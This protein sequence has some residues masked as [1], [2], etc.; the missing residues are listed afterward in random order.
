MKCVATCWATNPTSLV[1]NLIG[2]LVLSAIAF[3]AMRGA[4]AM[5]F[6]RV[7]GAARFSRPEPTLYQKCLAV[8]IQDAAPRSALQ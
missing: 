1:L 2:L 7:L 8:H 4:V 6:H 3:Y 5:V